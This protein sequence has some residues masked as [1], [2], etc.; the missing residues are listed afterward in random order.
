MRQQQLALTAAGHTVIMV[1][2]ARGRGARVRSVDDGIEITPLFFLPGVDLPIIANSAATRSTLDEL[3]ES[4][5]VEVVHVQTDFGLAHAAADVAAIRSIPVIH[6]VHTFYWASEDNWFNPLAGLA[7]WALT[8]ITG[9]DIPKE[10]FT[11][12]A[13][14]NLLRNVTL[15]MAQRADTVVSPSAHQARDLQA[16]GVTG[17]V[18]L[19][20]NPVSTSPRP[21]MPLPA[22]TSGPRFLWVARC[23][24]VK[25]PLPFARAAIEALKRT[26]GGFSIDFV[27]DGTEHA[28]LRRIVAGHPQLRVQ[29]SL[30][31]DDV[32][33]LMDAASIVV[34]TSVGFD[35]QPMTIAEAVSRHRG[36]LYCDPKLREGLLRAGY[37]APGH[38]EASLADAIVELVRDP[39]LMT[40]LS[41]GAAEDGA[42]FS[43]G[44]F[45]D[46]IV[47]V[48][49]AAVLKLAQERGTP[50]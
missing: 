49:D 4:R 1:S 50:H 48:F 41:H 11:P 2:A 13:V 31:H 37:L 30:P 8:R 22:P 19:V 33:D 14:D 40:Q 29:G 17:P 6:T 3:F 5:G 18:A 25:R 26:D 12:R 32:L 34:L 35:N 43:P 20:P 46:R 47:R 21:P 36:I 23:E 16:A 7:R 10:T 24:P 9:L 42:Q 39:L 27:G 45:V 28:E 38:D 44:V 15:G